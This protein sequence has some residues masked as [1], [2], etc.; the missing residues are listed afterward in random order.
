MT[1]TPELMIAIEACLQSGRALLKRARQAARPNGVGHNGHDRFSEGPAP[2]SGDLIGKRLSA[3]GLPVVNCHHVLQAYDERSS[4]YRF[5]LVDPLDGT[6]DAAS[7]SGECTVS[8]ALIEK[9]EPVLGVVYAPLTDDLYFASRETGAYRVRDASS[10]AASTCRLS[11][12][13]RN[14]FGREGQ[15]C[16]VLVG[17]ASLGDCAIRYLQEL[18]QHYDAI[19]VVQ[20]DGGLKLCM[21]ASGE[22]DLYP[23]FEDSSEWE[24]AAGHAILKAV[25]KNIVDIATGRELS[26]NKPEMRNPSF[27]AQ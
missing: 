5:W 17:R 8:A 11:R 14:S 1:L 13:G 10:P 18:R 2:E 19:D 22:A 12:E 27:I 4:W 25:G 3:T 15:V 7:G 16:R 24:T 23:R 9:G 6:Y 21:I 20:K 26:Y